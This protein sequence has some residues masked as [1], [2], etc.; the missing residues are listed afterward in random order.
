MPLQK[1]I[2][3]LGQYSSLVRLC[4]VA[5]YRIH[6]VDQTAV[7]AWKPRVLEDRYGIEPVLGYIID[8][9]SEGSLSK[10]NTVHVPLGPYDVAHVADSSPA[11][12]SQVENL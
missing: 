2:K 5:V 3:V 11:R 8:Q 1:C 4:N 9:V 10:F 7:P 6:F 12:R